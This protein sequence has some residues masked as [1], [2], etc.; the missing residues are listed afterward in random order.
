V[1]ENV[2]GDENAVELSVNLVKKQWKWKS[3]KLA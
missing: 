3:T 2:H 1:V